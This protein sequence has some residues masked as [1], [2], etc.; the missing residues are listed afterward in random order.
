M[1]DTNHPAIEGATRDLAE[2]TE[3]REEHP[4]TKLGALE[5]GALSCR[6]ECGSRRRAR[7]GL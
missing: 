1:R 2:A 4:E 6:R 7:T 3:G 5:S